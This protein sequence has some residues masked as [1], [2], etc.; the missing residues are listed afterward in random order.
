[1]RFSVFPVLAA[2]LICAS[3]VRPEPHGRDTIDYVKEIAAG[4]DSPE[5]QMLSSFSHVP[6]SGNICIIGPE[7]RNASLC[8]AFLDCDFF[9]NARGR[10]WSDGL[11]DFA[12]EFFSCINDTA[13]APYERFVNENGSEALREASV[14]LALAALSDRCSVS[15]YDL[16][17]N[18]TKTPGK[19]IILSD[20]WLQHCGKFDID[21]LF[22]LTSCKV[23]VISPQD[24]MF[25]AVFG[26]ERKS[27]NVGV[28]CDSAYIDSGIYREIYEAKAAEHDI[29]GSS[30]FQAPSAAAEGVLA[31]FLDSYMDAGKS[32]PL[33]V[34]LVDD[35][36]VDVEAMDAELA[37]VRDFSKEEYMRYGKLVSPSFRILSSS[38]MVMEYCY[39]LLREKSLFTHR[40]AQ[41]VSDS[42]TV[43]PRSVDGSAAFL[44][45]P[46]GNV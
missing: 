12:G 20:P 44:L 11:R 33:D 10:R 27:F 2:L 41:P 38:T 42:Y 45:I 40:I 3:C 8:L 23:P 4:A 6:S 7:E 46:S 14:R 26:E 36:A 28:V 18:R 16:D 5:H 35:W 34:L 19:L 21:T 1:M 39:A 17:E 24:L 37:A 13:F 43:M 31:S 30:F 29:V 15:V 22:S 32:E 9:E 25:D